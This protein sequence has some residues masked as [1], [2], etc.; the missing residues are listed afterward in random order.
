MRAAEA[1]AGRAGD[2]ADFG[3]IVLYECQQDAVGLLSR[4]P[5]VNALGECA[6]GVTGGRSPLAIE[7]TLIAPD[8]LELLL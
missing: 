3:E 4:Q 2:A 8:A 5:G 6:H 7:F 1:L